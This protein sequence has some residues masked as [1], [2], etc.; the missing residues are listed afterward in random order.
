MY[1]NASN[2]TPSCTHVS[3]CPGMQSPPP[4]MDGT[5]NV[6]CNNNGGFGCPSFLCQCSLEGI[7]FCL[8]PCNVGL[9]ELIVVVSELKYL[10][11][12][13]CGRNGG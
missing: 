9:R 5:S 4:G 6:G 11:S 13:G 10:K 3:S 1:A 12:W 7:V 8:F 2:N